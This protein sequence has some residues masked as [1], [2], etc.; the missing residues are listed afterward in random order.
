MRK[1]LSNGSDPTKDDLKS[2]L[3]CTKCGRC[4]RECKS[5]AITIGTA[6]GGTLIGARREEEP[7]DKSSSELPENIDVEL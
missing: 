1:G 5:N 4:V 6:F 3:D 7:E 2:K